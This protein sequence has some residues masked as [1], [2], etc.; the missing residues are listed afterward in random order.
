V[1]TVPLATEERVGTASLNG[2]RGEPGSLNSD[3][4]PGTV[5]VVIADPH[6]LCVDSLE[7]MIMTAPDLALCAAVRTGFAALEEVRRHKPDV[8][9]LDL[10]FGDLDGLSILNAIEREGLPTRCVF[11]TREGDARR[12]FEAISAGARGFL[13]SHATWEELCEAIREA[14]GAWVSGG[15][16]AR[17]QSALVEEMC[18]D[19]IPDTPRIDDGT[20]EVLQLTADELSPNQ[21]ARALHLAPATVKGRMHAA[22]KQLGVKTATGV[23]VEAHRRGLIH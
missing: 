10:A 14:A 4:A 2:H 17:V 5:R 12:A 1:C 16:S 21:I 3:R 20:R 19:A 22:Y 18:R 9:L 23:A 15:I 8:A 7:R 6:E 13:D 11:L